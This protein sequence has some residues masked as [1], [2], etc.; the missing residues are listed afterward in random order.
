[1][2]KTADSKELHAQINDFYELCKKNNTPVLTLT[3][4]SAEK[5]N[6]FKHKHNA[7]YDFASVDA[8]V[9]KTMIRSNPGLI[10]MKECKVI[11]N[12]HYRNWPAYSD[13][14]AKYMK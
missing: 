5:I 13:A 1:L 14:K 10:L 3:A 7:L 2:D 12:W 4:S 6:E 11:N 9:L 8:I